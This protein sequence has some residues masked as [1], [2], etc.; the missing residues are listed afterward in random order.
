MLQRSCNLLVV[1]VVLLYVCNNFCF[2]ISDIYTTNVAKCRQHSKNIPR[3]SQESKNPE[4][5]FENV[6]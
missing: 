1:S 6:K 3:K 5:Y 4:N 2:I